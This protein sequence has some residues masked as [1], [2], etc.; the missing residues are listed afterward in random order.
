MMKMVQTN[1]DAA[2]EPLDTYKTK[3]KGPTKFE[4]AVYGEHLVS[5]VTTNFVDIWLFVV[6]ILFTTAK[7]HS[8]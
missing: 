5:K 7:H 1:F 3:A 6:Y 2:V 4:R 8:K